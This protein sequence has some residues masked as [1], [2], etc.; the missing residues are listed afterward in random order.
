MTQ[1]SILETYISA[2]V[3]QV[4]AFVERPCFPVAFLVHDS[5]FEETHQTLFKNLKKHMTY[6]FSPIVVS[7]GELAAV[8]AT[9]STFPHWNMVSCWNHILTDVEVWL[10]KHHVCATEIAIYK[11]AIHELLQCQALEEYKSKLLTL[12]TTWTELSRIT[13]PDTY[14]LK[15]FQHTLVT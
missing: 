5:K 15:F 8:N 14:Q 7:D 11:S 13:T 10:K 12:S 4:E 2:L 6:T 3:A 1:H 9:N